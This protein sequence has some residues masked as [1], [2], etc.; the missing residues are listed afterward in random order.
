MGLNKKNWAQRGALNRQST[1][2]TYSYPH[3][4]SLSSLSLEDAEVEDFSRSEDATENLPVSLMYSDTVS[5]SELLETWKR[6]V[7]FLP[8]LST[9]EDMISNNDAIHLSCYDWHWN[10]LFYLHATL[11][12]NR[13]LIIIQYIFL[14]ILDT[15][16]Q[17]L[18]I[19][20][21]FQLSYFLLFL[22][23]QCSY[24]LQFYFALIFLTVFSSHIY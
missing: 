24:L 18:H 23:S 13:L 19:S 14:Q 2:I 1:G 10:W 3:L 4:L 9:A 21:A 20:Y 5:S 12:L 16:I 7:A 6:L 15:P 22:L 8:F 17:W 11:T